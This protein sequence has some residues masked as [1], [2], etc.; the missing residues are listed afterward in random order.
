MAYATP[1]HWAFGDKP[2]ATEFNKY[3][4]NL[5][6]ILAI[7]DGKNWV[8]NGKVFEEI[9]NQDVAIV[10]QNWHSWLVYRTDASGAQ[11]VSWTDANDTF[12]LTETE[13][14]EWAILDLETVEWLAPGILYKVEGCVCALETELLQ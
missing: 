10:H 3:A 9:E 8:S 11:L 7:Y 5:A 13:D 6:E 12:G 14:D 2:N 4:T 1:K